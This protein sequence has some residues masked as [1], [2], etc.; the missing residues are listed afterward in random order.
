MHYGARYYLPGLARFAS[1]DTMVPGAGNPQALNR[2]SY[3]LS[4]PLKYTDPSGHCTV[5]VSLPWGGVTINVPSLVCPGQDDLIDDIGEDVL[6][7]DIPE[8]AGDMPMN[9]VLLGWEDVLRPD[10]PEWGDF[11]PQDSKPPAMMATAKKGDS[12]KGNDLPIETHHLLTDKHKSKWTA[13]FGKITGKYNLDLDDDWNKVDIPHKGRHADQYHDWG[14]E[15]LKKIDKEARGDQ[16]IFLK[17]FEK[18][19][20]RPVQKNPDMVRKKWWEDKQE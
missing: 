1:A 6:R 7:V 19:V 17:L 12:G 20:K 10:I 13:I 16:G 2:F 11:L 3:S 18:F 4:N 5:P 8:P 15:Q 14:N 9:D